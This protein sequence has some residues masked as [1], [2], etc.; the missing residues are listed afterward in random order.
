MALIIVGV[1]SLAS[2]RA[3]RWMRTNIPGIHI[4]DHI[5][6]RLE[7]V[8][9]QEAEAVNI[10]VELVQKFREIEGVSGIHFMARSRA[11]II[12]SIIKRSEI[13][14]KRQINSFYK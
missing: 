1:G 4:P 7:K 9:E 12:F 11:H 2:A 8:D 3:A 14:H 10:C 13:L 5:I 6:H